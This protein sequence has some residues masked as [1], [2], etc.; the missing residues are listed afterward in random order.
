MRA[1]FRLAAVAAAAILP[2]AFAAEPLTKPQLEAFER[3]ASGAEARIAW[4]SEIGR[5]ETDQDAAADQGI[6]TISILAVEDPSQNNR[7]TRGI[8]IDLVSGDLRDQVYANEEHLDRLISAMEEI[9]AAVPSAAGGSAVCRGSCAFLLDVRQDA[10]AFTASACDSADWSG[11]V[12]GPGSIRFRGKRA[13]DFVEVF[14][15][16]QRELR[17]YQVLASATN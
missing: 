11:L 5:I 7:Q 2:G 6:A 1:F 17:R 12:V 3:L 13:A 10:H 16:A 4:S 9:D 15:S 8:R 14:R